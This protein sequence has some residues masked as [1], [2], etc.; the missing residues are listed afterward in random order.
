MEIELGLWLG[1]VASKVREVPLDESDVV[2]LLRV[3]GA[4]AVVFMIDRERPEAASITNS[5]EKILGHLGERHLARAG[6][7]RDEVLWVY[8]DTMG[9]WDRIVGRYA[10]EHTWQ[11]CGVDFAPAELGKAAQFPVELTRQWLQA[12]VLPEMHGA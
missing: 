4:R 8:R 12:E 2:V 9:R 6:V 11:P 5:A 1:A 10:S 7:H 3:E